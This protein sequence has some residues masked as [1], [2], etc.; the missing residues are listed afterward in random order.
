MTIEF[1]ITYPCYSPMVNSVDPH[2]FTIEGDQAVGIFTDS[3]L[4]QQYLQ[5]LRKNPLIAVRATFKTPENLASYLQ[6]LLDDPPPGSPTHVILDPSP[7]A[8]RAAC[9][10]IPQFLAHVLT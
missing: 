9:Y 10:P 7:L 1:L 2:T 3:H 8:K 6:S 4:L 5:S